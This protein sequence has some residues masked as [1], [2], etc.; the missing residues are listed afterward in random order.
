MKWKKNGY[1]YLI[2]LFYTITVGIG[3]F[4]TVKFMGSLLE[5]SMPISIIISSILLLLMGAFVLFLY[6]FSGGFCNTLKGKRKTAIT[7]EIAIAA[8]LFFAGVLIILNTPYSNVGEEYF[9]I[10]CVKEGTGVP[11]LVHGAVYLYLQYLHTVCLFFGNKFIVCIWAQIILYLVAAIV[12]YFA[13]RRLAGV[14]PAMVLL[15]FMMFAKGLQRKALSLNPNVLFLLLFAIALHMVISCLESEEKRY[16]LYIIT[17]I[18]I[19]LMIFID[20]M[21]ITLLLFLVTILY[22]E[23]QNVNK[24]FSSAIISFGLSL[25]ACLLSFFGC[26]LMDALT[27]NKSFLTILGLWIELFQPAQWSVLVTPYL[28]DGIVEIILL[29]LGLTMGIFSFFS[30]KKQ[31]RISVFFLPVIALIVAQGFHITTSSMD[32][33][34]FIYLFAA[35]LCGI[36]IDNALI[37][38]LAKDPKPIESKVCQCDTEEELEPIE[39]P[40][41]PNP[42]PLPKKHVPRV[43]DYDIEVAD[44]DD[45]DI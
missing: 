41:I 2:W 39:I 26:I 34:L 38:E 12:V 13:I 20:I 36:G 14:L 42:L 18:A 7:L 32:G 33:S 29:F 28:G 40:L 15:G 3:L 4:A 9:Q 17:G 1:S 31:E 21:G 37:K 23:K 30:S 35:A 5:Y 44:D 27:C 43:L 16:F 11:R 22:R 45:Y 10:A 6:R 8:S 19:G 25:L 24:G